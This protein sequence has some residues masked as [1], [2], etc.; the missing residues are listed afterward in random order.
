MRNRRWITIGVLACGLAMTLAV[1]DGYAGSG[2][3]KGY[4]REAC[5]DGGWKHSGSGRL[6]E[7][8]FHKSHMI[9]RYEQEL[10]LSEEQVERV[11]TIMAETQKRL[12]RDE[13]DI[14]VLSVDLMRELHK[15][16]IDVQTA[17]SILDKQYEVK[18]GK[19]MALVQSLAD[20]KA[21]LT[22][23]QYAKLKEL[24]RSAKE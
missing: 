12:I 9:L 23:E 7:I 3:G 14:D 22:P 24:Y 10:G 11:K 17:R 20:L 2:N 19:A 4:G 13:A 15:A 6:D 8:F 21:T 16:T 5:D 18:K 1:G